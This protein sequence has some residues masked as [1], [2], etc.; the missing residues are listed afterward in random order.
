MIDIREGHTLKQ[1]PAIFKKLRHSRTSA[2]LLFL[3]A[4]DRTIVRRFSE[5]RRPHPL[6]VDASVLKSIRDEREQLAPI[7][8]CG[9]SHH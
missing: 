1:F 8:R 4:D 3:E 5:T 6:G 9:R 7:R 2:T